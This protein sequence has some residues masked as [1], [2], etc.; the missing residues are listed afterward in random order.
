[1]RTLIVEDDELTR[2]LFTSFLIGHGKADTAVDGAKG[3]ERFKEAHEKGEPYDL[4]CLDLMM[5]GVNGIELLQM[6]REEEGK[7]DIPEEKRS[8]IIMTTAVSQDSIIKQAY[9]AKCDGYLI[10][11]IK[12]SQLL[13]AVREMGLI[14]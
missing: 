10:K 7:M 3:F 4:L 2:M 8:R 12:R 5:P 11:P 6:V 14:D 9:D 1:M 13:D